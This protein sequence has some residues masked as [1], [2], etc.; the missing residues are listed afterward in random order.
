MIKKR[1]EKQRK[2]ISLTKKIMPCDFAGCPVFPVMNA[3]RITLLVKTSNH[4]HQETAGL[5]YY[6]FTNPYYMD[7]TN[8]KKA[9]SEIGF[10]KGR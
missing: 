7:N 8:A 10:R 4:F 9:A 1:I 2:H 6:E 5:F 3:Q